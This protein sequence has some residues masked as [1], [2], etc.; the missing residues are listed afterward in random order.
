M[1]RG[2][3]ERLDM[4]DPAFVVFF[5]EIKISLK[6]KSIHVSLYTNKRQWQCQ[7]E[8]LIHQEDLERV[9]DLFRLSK[10]V[11]SEEVGTKHNEEL[12]S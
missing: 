6:G 12:E 11:T 9:S 2:K 10:S 4:H 5:H 7:N 3:R 8:K 1:S